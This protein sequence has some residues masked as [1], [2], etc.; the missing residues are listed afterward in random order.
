MNPI[1]ALAAIR[2]VATA[3]GDL[4]E[5]VMFVGG[6]VTGLLV[7]DPAAPASRLTVDVDVVVDI[8]TRADYVRLI[9][10]LRD[11]GFVED[12]REG[13]PTC[14]WVV[15]G[16]TVDVMSAGPQPGPTSRWYAE[17]LA[18]ADSVAITGEVSVRVI[19]APYFLATK[20]EAFGDGRRDDLFA[21]RDIEDVVA[22]IDGRATIEH[23]IVAARPSVREYLREQFRSLL[24]NPDFDNAVAGHLPGDSASQAR[25][26]L[27]LSRMRAIATAA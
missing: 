4:R 9:E 18:H 2:I 11:L 22:V 5:D 12:T 17:A 26:P 14:R 24:A 13:A 6:A 25:L 16:I 1:E 10:Q 20:L 15:Q 3:F 21:S 19:S 23:E 7:T 27:V 8:A